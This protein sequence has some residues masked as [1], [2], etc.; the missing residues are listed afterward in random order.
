MEDTAIP[1]PDTKKKLSLQTVFRGKESKLFRKLPRNL[2]TMAPTLFAKQ[3][4]TIFIVYFLM[5]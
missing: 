1:L 2:E 4:E 5:A 3:K